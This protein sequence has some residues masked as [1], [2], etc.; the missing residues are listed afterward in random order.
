MG[1]GPKKDNCAIDE[2]LNEIKTVL[3]LIHSLS[4][5]LNAVPPMLYVS[6]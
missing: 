5:T 2:S 3:I 4:I 6:Y 1:Q